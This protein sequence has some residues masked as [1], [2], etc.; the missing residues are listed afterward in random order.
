MSA[1]LDIAPPLVTLQALYEPRA[2]ILSKDG[3]AQE[4]VR[5]C[6]DT[7]GLI[8]LVPNATV[9]TLPPRSSR[10]TVRVSVCKELF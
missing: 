10:M 8:P 3:P 5:C 2:G 1:L 4:R 9:A 6:S 7:P